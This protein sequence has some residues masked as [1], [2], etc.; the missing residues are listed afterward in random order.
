MIYSHI[1][2]IKL[3]VG[4]ERCQYA[5]SRKNSRRAS[6]LALR[7]C[8]K[9]SVAEPHVVSSCISELAEPRRAGE[10]HTTVDMFG[11]WVVEINLRHRAQKFDEI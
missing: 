8:G 3:N 11:R 4:C 10:P 9:I 2:N 7:L 5:F 6:T 1:T